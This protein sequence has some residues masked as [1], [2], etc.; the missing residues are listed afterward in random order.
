V[1]PVGGGAKQQIVALENS[2]REAL[3]WLR[4]FLDFFLQD[5]TAWQK[6]EENFIAMQ[7]KKQ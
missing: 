2:K 4:H 7:V 6:E 5:F 1:V 3:I